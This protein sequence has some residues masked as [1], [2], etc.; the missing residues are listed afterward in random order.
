MVINLKD[1][2]ER[3]SVQK[4]RRP[5]LFKRLIQHE[6]APPHVGS[7]SV[8]SVESWPSRMRLNSTGKVVKHQQN[9]E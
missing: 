3:H 8:P 7:G 4:Y 2:L 1:W 9:G 6:N 5:E